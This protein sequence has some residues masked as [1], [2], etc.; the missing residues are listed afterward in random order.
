LG[1]DITARFRSVSE[2]NLAI[3]PDVD[4]DG[5]WE[6]FVNMIPDSNAPGWDDLLTEFDQASLLIGV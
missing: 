1:Q 4:L 3:A 6:D 5:L 2:Q